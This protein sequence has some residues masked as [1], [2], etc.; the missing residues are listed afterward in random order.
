MFELD[1]VK[2]DIYL[3]HLSRDNNVEYANIK[4][5]LRHGRSRYS[6]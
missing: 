6:L 3:G 1:G 4:A 5:D 2:V